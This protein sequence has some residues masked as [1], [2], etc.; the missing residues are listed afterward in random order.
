MCMIHLDLM[1]VHID[2]ITTGWEQVT[3]EISHM[4]PGAKKY[5][6]GNIYRP[7]ERYVVELDLFIDEFS[8]CID[9]LIGLN[10]VS[11]ICGD[12]NINLLEITANK[13]ASEY[14]ESICSRGFYP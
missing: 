8:N 10:R 12:F 4:T 13:Y 5:L 14:V 9:S 7:Q 1:K 6:I 2:Q 3:V 11:Y